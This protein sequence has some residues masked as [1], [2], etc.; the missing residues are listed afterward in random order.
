MKKTHFI[1]TLALLAAACD[2]QQDDKIDIGAPPAEATFTITPLTTPNYYLL[3]NT[4][5][6]VFECLWDLGNGTRVNGEQ[7]EAYYPLKGTYTITLTVFGRGGHATSSQ[8][9]VVPEDAPFDCESDELY[10]YL[11]DCQQRTWRLKPTEGS[12]WVGPADGSTTWWAISQNE[13]NNRPCEFNDEWTFTKDGMLIYD[14]KGDVFAEPYMGFNYE[15][16]E[17][18]MLPP[19]KAPWGSGTHTFEVLPNNKLKVVG[20]GAYLGLP[21]VANGAEVNVPQTSVTYDIIRWDTTPDGKEMELEIN[22]G[23]GIWRFVYISPN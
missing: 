23:A 1:A 20:L 2:P 3:T 15:C 16:I 9:L 12:L 10:Q 17:A 5:P 4:T 13:V 19:D 8:T 7:V 6:D 14:T 21:K 11:T 22:F 18:S